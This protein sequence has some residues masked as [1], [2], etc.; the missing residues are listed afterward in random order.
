MTSFIWLLLVAAPFAQTEVCPGPLTAAYMVES[1]DAVDVAI[2]EFNGERANGLLDDLLYE[3][4]C[5]EHPIDPRHLGRLAR[6]LSLMS[7]YEQDVLETE[8]WALLARST[9]G[10][11][12]WPSGIPIPET[13]H[14]FLAELPELEEV[15]VEGAGLAP[16]K[17]GAILMDGRVLLRPRAALGTSHLVQVADKKGAVS[18][19]RWQHG[20]A[21]DESLLGGATELK[22]PRWYSEP[23]PPAPP[24]LALPVA[25]PDPAP[26]S[27][28]PDSVPVP[29]TVP[30]P[31]A[32][33]VADA[34]LPSEVRDRMFRS[35]EATEGCPWKKQPMVAV[36]KA[37]EVRVNRHSYAV[38]SPAQ[39]AEFR[40]V[41][42]SCGEFRAARR[43]ERW[44]D[45]RRK[46][47]LD[48][49]RYKRGMVKAL[50]TDE[51]KKRRKPSR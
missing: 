38:K 5:L 19:T 43:F 47:A 13:Y 48:A 42:R 2:S 40:S 22:A 51:P 18:A 12:P 29:D 34:E 26:E 24:V 45:A 36:A 17:K 35:R 1:M 6:Q 8:S 33:P 21:F 32:D 49:G 15:E 3:L 16:P 20:A 28:V 46:L 30:E 23:E 37:G 41:L 7:F 50:L 44:R 39:Q 9:L 14:G 27:E 11:A 31:V 25:E 4:R 10:G